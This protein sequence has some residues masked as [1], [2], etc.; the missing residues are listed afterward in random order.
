[1]IPMPCGKCN[2]CV[3]G[4]EN[5]CRRLSSGGEPAELKSLAR[6]LHGFSLADGESIAVLGED[7]VAHWFRRLAGPRL[8]QESMAEL[9]VVSG[10]DL[11]AAQ[12]RVARGGTILLYGAATEVRLD[13]TRLHYDQITLQAVHGYRRQDVEAARRR[14]LP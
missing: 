4:L 5:L 9:V 12:W 11:E 14:L 3:S 2:D 6:A 1:M 7:P 10:G 8:V 13:T